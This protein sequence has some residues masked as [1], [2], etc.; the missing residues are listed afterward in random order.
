MTTEE[1][2]EKVERELADL[3]VT[4]ASM[5]KEIRTEQLVLGDDNGTVYGVLNGSGLKLYGEEGRDEEG[6]EDDDGDG[7]LRAEFGVDVDDNAYLGLYGEEYD[8]PRRRSVLLSAGTEGPLLKL[9]SHE[10][11]GWHTAPLSQGGLV[12]DEALVSAILIAGEEGLG[13]ELYSGVG[14]QAFKPSA[15]RSGTTRA[16]GKKLGPLINSQEETF[17]VLSAG[18]N[19]AGLRF[20]DKRGA[21]EAKTR[22][23]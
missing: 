18:V 10:G 20:W 15:P 4:L 1:R 12:C 3:R 7:N 16:L 19:G 2:L 5:R 17:T 8:P 14:D 13:L 21:R 9:Q 23:A 11:S 6:D 22:R